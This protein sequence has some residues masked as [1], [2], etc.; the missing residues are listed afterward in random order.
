MPICPEDRGSQQRRLIGLLAIEG[1]LR[2]EEG[3]CREG[4]FLPFASTKAERLA[5]GDPRLSVAERYK[6]QDGFVR[7]VREAARE[8]VRERFL[9]QVDADAFISAAQ[10]SNILK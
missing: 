8:L 5:T 2:N 4:S 7:A 9:L 6:T 3:L 1:P 10:A